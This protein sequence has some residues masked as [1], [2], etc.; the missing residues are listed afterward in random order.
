MRLALV[1]NITGNAAVDP[2][3]S[4]FVITIKLLTV[5]VLNADR[6]RALLSGAIVNSYQANCCTFNSTSSSGKE[7]ATYLWLTT[8]TYTANIQSYDT[9]GEY[10]EF[11]WRF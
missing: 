11:V 8:G 5:H 3:I 7:P 10:C 2:R 6:F 4:L 9:I 1:D